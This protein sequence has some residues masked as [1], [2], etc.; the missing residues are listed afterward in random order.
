MIYCFTDYYEEDDDEYLWFDEVLLG[1]NRI[2]Y[3][4]TE[5]LPHW[6]T[7]F[8]SFYLN[9]TDYDEEDDCDE[10]EDDD[11]EIVDEFDLFEKDDDF[12]AELPGH[13]PER[14]IYTL[15][16]AFPDACLVE[17]S[18]GRCIRDLRKLSPRA[19]KLRRR[20]YSLGHLLPVEYK[21]THSFPFFTFNKVD[22]LDE[23]HIFRSR[24]GSFYL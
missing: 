6:S 7:P 19:H 5:P 21:E 8:Q 11:E 20:Y 14:K 13:D 3:T 4:N 17:L 9:S 15:E 2:I 23:Q 16:C 12:Y 1:D 18:N 24:D 22:D 10:E